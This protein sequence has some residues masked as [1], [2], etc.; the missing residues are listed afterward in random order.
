MKKLL[1]SAGLIFC[2]FCAT[3]Q[4]G[5]GTSGGASGSSISAAGDF[6]LEVDHPGGQGARIKS[7]SSYSVVDVDGMGDA[8]VRFKS[9]G[10]FQWMLWNFQDDFRIGKH[11]SLLNDP[12]IFIENDNN[13]VGI[14]DDNPLLRMH[15]FGGSESIGSATG[16]MAIGNDGSSHMNLDPNEIDSY[17]SSGE[18]TT[19]YLNYNAEA[20]VY[21]R[22]ELNVIGFAGIGT[23]APQEKLTV[24]DGDFLLETGSTDKVLIENSGSGSGGE[25]TLNTNTGVKSIEIR[26]SDG[27]GLA[28][29]ILMYDPSDNSKTME[30]DGDWSGS[31]KSRIVVD[32][33]QITGGSDL[34]EYFDVLPSESSIEP[35]TVL[36]VSSDGSA[37]LEASKLAYDAKVV[38]VVSGANGVSTGLMLQQSGNEKTD[39]EY[40]VA[41]AGR[42]YVKAEA[43]QGAI[44][45]G[46][47]LT[48]SAVEGYAQ[49][50]K[51]YKKAQGAIIGKALTGLDEGEGYVL[52]LLGVK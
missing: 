19:L 14:G 3:A 31:G 32:E 2:A 39:G 25:I 24:R 5:A 21:I 22:D 15:V 30:I 40:P 49:K 11:G 41:I 46:D 6:T 34:S 51:R 10:V 52:V 44:R 12:A 29:E 8:S 37:K 36:S 27:T 9:D 1:L 33:L 42:V 35:G 47:L 45:P 20:P 4:K 18:G 13:F 23:T 50:V 28:G 48:S 26:A 38:G 43:S 17:L 7:Q 16:F